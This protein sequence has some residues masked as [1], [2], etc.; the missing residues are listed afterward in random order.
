MVAAVAVSAAYSQVKITSSAV[1]GL[2]SCQVTP[3]LIFQVTFIPSL[4]RPP[5]WRLGTS[6][7]RMGT[8]LPSGSKEQSGS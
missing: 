1:N 2:P 3:C 5:F 7:A 8:R 6:W 4:E